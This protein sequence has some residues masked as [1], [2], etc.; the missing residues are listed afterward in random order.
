MKEI[1]K[2]AYEYRDCK[3]WKRINEDRFF[4][5]RLDNGKLAYINIMGKNLPYMAIN[6]QI[7][8]YGLYQ[9]ELIYNNDVFGE[10][11]DFANMMEASFKQLIFGNKSDVLEEEYELVR[12]FKKEEG[13][14]L[15]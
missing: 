2:L 14:L 12:D 1:L 15:F 11:E 8:Y 13:L 3:L 4:A 7:G 5:I 9:I 10:Y 6:M